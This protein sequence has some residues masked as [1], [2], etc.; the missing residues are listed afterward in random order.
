MKTI[1]LSQADS[2]ILGF[3]SRVKYATPYGISITLGISE[4]QTG[5][6]LSRLSS[7]KLIQETANPE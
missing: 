3:L 4:K 6:A 7:F 1:K 5:I 2:N